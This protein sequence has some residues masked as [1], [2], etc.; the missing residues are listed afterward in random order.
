[1]SYFRI[2]QRSPPKA[3]RSSR[4][5]DSPAQRIFGH[6]NTDD[7]TVADETLNAANT[8]TPNSVRLQLSHRLSRI[9]FTKRSISRWRSQQDEELAD[10][11]SGMP[12]PPPIPSALQ[13][14]TEST[15]TPLPILSMM[16]LS[17]VR[18]LPSRYISISEAVI[19]RL[20]SAS[21]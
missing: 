2:P 18:Y 14:S 8:T 1:M 19:F 7:S 16:V 15:S 10:G 11:S 12:A 9:S 13:Q 20:F 4:M 5:A 17:I 6:P 21:S 3:R